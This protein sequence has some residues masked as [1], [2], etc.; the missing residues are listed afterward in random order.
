LGEW[1]KNLKKADTSVWKGSNQKRLNSPLRRKE[2]QK[3][4]E[5]N[6]ALAQRIVSKKSNFEFTRS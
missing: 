1:K 3:I 5:E 2:L 6:F 4:E